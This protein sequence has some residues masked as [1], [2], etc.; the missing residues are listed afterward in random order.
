VNLNC[1][2]HDY[3]GGDCLDRSDA[4]TF[5]EVVTTVATCA[6]CAWNQSGNSSDYVCAKGPT[7]WIGDGICDDGTYSHG[8]GEHACARVDGGSN[9]A[10]PFSDAATPA[11]FFYFYFFLLLLL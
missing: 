4:M 2:E 7:S 1:S 10:R 6:G 8:N 11:A 3:D 5:P 9:G